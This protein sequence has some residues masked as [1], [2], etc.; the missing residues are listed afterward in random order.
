MSLMIVGCIFFL[1]V[2]LFFVHLIDRDELGL[3][4]KDQRGKE[5]GKSYHSQILS[6][7]PRWKRLLSKNVVFPAL[8][9]CPYNGL[10]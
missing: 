7:V 2:E 5:E 8:Q 1:F 4:T 6:F 3:M 10:V 9:F